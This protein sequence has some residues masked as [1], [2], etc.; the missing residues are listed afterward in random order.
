MDHDE[1]GERSLALGKGE[2]RFAAGEIDRLTARSRRLLRRQ[3]V[4][5]LELFLGENS[6][7]AHGGRARGRRLGLR[8]GLGLLRAR[9]VGASES[10]DGSKCGESSSVVHGTQLPGDVV[11]PR[12]SR[13][14]GSTTSPPRVTSVSRRISSERSRFS[15][16]SF[17]IMSTSVAT[18]FENIW[19]A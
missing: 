3:F 16:P 18:F 5:R 13:T 14:R 12:T 1:P 2:I 9:G 8:F 19:L 7:P 6:G 15:F 17:A 11:R 10:D 4:Q